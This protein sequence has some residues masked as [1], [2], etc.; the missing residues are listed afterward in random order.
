V[1]HFFSHFASE[2]QR[3]AL[4][5]AL[6]AAGMGTPGR[7]SEIDSD[8]KLEGDGYWHHWAFTVLNAVPAELEAV[9]GK[10]RRSPRHTVCSTTVGLCNGTS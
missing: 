10:R 7:G 3:E 8:E 4:R 6:R 9:G 1:T 2:P 5:E